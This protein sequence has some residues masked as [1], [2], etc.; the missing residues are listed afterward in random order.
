[1]YRREASWV[2][3]V[4]TCSIFGCGDILAATKEAPGGRCR[5]SGARRR[6]LRAMAMSINLDLEHVAPPPR[7]KDFRIGAIGAGFIMNDCH[8]VAYGHAGYNVV[9]I[10]SASLEESR[11]V[12]QTHGIP[13]MYA[14]HQELLADPAIEVVDIAVPPDKQLMIVGEAV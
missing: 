8:L 3:H 7:R 1:M 6:G 2:K 12:A 11:H 5:L 4:V 14:T 9:A 13:K 10:A